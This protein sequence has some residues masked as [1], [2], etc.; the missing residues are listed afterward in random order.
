MSKKTG[1]GASLAFSNEIAYSSFRV[2]SMGGM[3]EYVDELDDTGLDSA[4]FYEA[5]PDDLLKVD[6]FDVT[7]Y[8]DFTKNISGQ[9]GKVGTIT[10]TLPLQPGQ[11]TPARFIGTGFIMRNNNPELSA[12]TR[13]TNTL[14][15]KFDGKTG[16]T[17]TPAA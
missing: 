3:S 14:S 5:C 7:V 11:S 16:P 2:Q 13:L 12:G 4:G 9:I 6:P 1:I 17:F 10:L 8:S 15:I